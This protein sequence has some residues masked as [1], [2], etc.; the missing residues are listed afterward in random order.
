MEDDASF[1][2]GDEA[3]EQGAKVSLEVPINVL[4]TGRLDEETSAVVPH[5]S[6]TSG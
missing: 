1:R 3:V 5:G 4:R 6:R 2:E